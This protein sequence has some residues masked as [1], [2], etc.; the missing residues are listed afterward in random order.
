[1]IQ[2]SVTLSP[3]QIAVLRGVQIENDTNDQTYY[4]ISHFISGV[5]LLLNERLV[6]HSFNGE[7]KGYRYDIT[8]KGRLLLRVI[9]LDVKDFAE[10][11]SLE[12]ERIEEKL[13]QARIDAAP[14]VEAIV[15]ITEKEGTR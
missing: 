2:F 9:E 14:P 15:S 8:E 6:T 5:R 1:M 10:T 7:G 12:T 3:N 4:A 11:V 13:R